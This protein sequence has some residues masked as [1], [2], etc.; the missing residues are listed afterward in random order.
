MKERQFQSSDIVTSISFFL[1]LVM[2]LPREFHSREIRSKNIGLWKHRDK[3]TVELHAPNHGLHSNAIYA[4]C[5]KCLQK[6]QDCNGV[7]NL[8]T[9]ESCPKAPEPLL[10]SRKFQVSLTQFTA[11]T[12][13]LR[14]ISFPQFINSVLHIHHSEENQGLLPF[15]RI[16]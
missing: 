3:N 8:C 13:V 7:L 10:N 12:T 14:F 16:G 15:A 2:A 1:G 6:S 4:N 9:F 5:S 11:A